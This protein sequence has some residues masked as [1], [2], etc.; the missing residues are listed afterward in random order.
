MIPRRQRGGDAGLLPPGGG[1]GDAAGKGKICM[2]NQMIGNDIV[3]LK[4][5]D[6]RGKAGDARFIARVFTVSEQEAIRRSAHPD[7]LLWTFWAAKE[8]AYKAISKAAPDISSAPRHYRVAIDFQN[9]QNQ[10][11]NAAGDVATP[12]GVAPVRIFCNMEW[13]H[14]MASAGLTATPF[15][16]GII[17]GIR[18]ITPDRRPVSV[19]E[20]ATAREAATAGIASFLGINPDDIR[21][22]RETGP[23]GQGPPMVH[24]KGKRAPIDISLSHDGRF[25]AYAF[26]IAPQ[27]E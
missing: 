2:R 10:P 12:L 21:I 3:D 16:I 9:R 14:C 18:E 7:A 20:S 8:A 27:S 6:A 4:T 25:A 13:V 19:R 15:D 1:A 17:Y 26:W 5:A 24:I 11:E 23:R 22:L